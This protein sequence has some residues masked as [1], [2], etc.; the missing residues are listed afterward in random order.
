MTVRLTVF[1]G[2]NMGTALLGGLVAAGWAPAT[3][4][5]VVEP[6]DGRRL[7]LRDELP[8][9]AVMAEAPIASEAAVLAVKPADVPAAA[10]AA[11]RGGARPGAGVAPGVA[12]GAP[13]R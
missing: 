13:Q 1:G 11:G 3:E 4:L 2:G 10:A 7:V 6:V 5:A 8:G 9:V 12:A